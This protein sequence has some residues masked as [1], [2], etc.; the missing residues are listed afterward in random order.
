[1][2]LRWCPPAR[3]ADAPCCELDAPCKA[4]SLI[5]GRLDDAALG[6]LHACACLRGSLAAKE[7]DRPACACTAQQKPF[8]RHP[9]GRAD[10]KLRV[11]ER[12]LKGASGCAGAALP[13]A[14]VSAAFEYAGATGVPLAGFLGDEC[15]T[16]RM[17][18]ELE[19]LRAD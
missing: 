6:R 2:G 5:R 11:T 17:T 19:V 15:V 13:R 14:V 16:L 3:A 4:R 18:P 7:T 8:S 12:R 10:G 1:M 9:W